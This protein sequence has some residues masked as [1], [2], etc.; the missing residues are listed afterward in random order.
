MGR[1]KAL[2]P[3]GGQPLLA[4]VVELLGAV[5][6]ERIV[7]SREDL[8][9]PRVAARVVVDA[10]PDLGPLGG[11]R[12]ALHS[13]SADR[14]VVT[15]TDLPFLDVGCLERLMAEHDRDTTPEVEGE[16]RHRA[17]VGVYYYEQPNDE[18]E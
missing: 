18:D 9:L 6:E 7:V 10:T 17:M 5:A 15:S 1:A 11:I 4:H 8:V 13:M 16:G 14:A 12:D 2:L 3:W